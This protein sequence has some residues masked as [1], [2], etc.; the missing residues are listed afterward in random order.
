MKKKTSLFYSFLI[1]IT[2][3]FGLSFLPNTIIKASADEV[4]VGVVQVQYTN[5]N[6]CLDT[7]FTEIM[8]TDENGRLAAIATLSKYP[9]YF[10][11]GWVIKDTT[12]LITTDTVFT[13]PLTVLVPILKAKTFVYTIKQNPDTSLTVVGATEEDGL[14]YTLTTTAASLSDVHIA[15]NADNQTS[16]PSTLVFDNYVLATGEQITASKA[17][18]FSGNITSSNESSIFKVTA[19]SA[20]TVAFKDLTLTNNS[21]GTFIDI[22]STA[23]I[24]L[25]LDSVAFNTTVTNSTAINITDKTTITLAGTMSNTASKLYKYVEG[26]T[27][28]LTSDTLTATTPLNIAIDYVYDYLE[29]TTNVYPLNYDH[30][31]FVA[32]KDFYV[33]HKMMSNDKLIARTSLNLQYNTNGGQFAQGYTAPNVYYGESY[34]AINL[35]TTSNISKDYATFDGWFG[36]ITITEEQREANNLSATTYYFDL[37]NVGLYIY[38][39]A[40]IAD[41]DTYFKTDLNSFEIDSSITAYL[42]S[43]PATDYNYWANFFISFEARPTLIAKWNAILYTITFESNGGSTVDSYVKPQGETIARPEPTKT[44]YTFTNWYID[45]ELTTVY[46]FS[47]MPAESFTL[48]AGYQINSYTIN[49]E[50]NNG[51]S[52]SSITQEYLTSIE[53]PE[54]ELEGHSFAGWFTESTF[55]NEFTQ[56]TIPANNLTLY[57][58]WTR[59]SYAINLSTDGK[60]ILPQIITEYGEVPTAPEDPVYDGY[61]FHGWYTDKTYTTPFDFS[62][63]TPAESRTAYAKWTVISYTLTLVYNNGVA[64]SVSSK[65]FESKINVPAQPTRTGYLFAGW[66]SDSACTTRFEFT[67]AHMPAR[68]LTLYAKWTAK[69]AIALTLNKQTVEVDGRGV[70]S[71]PSNLSGFTVYYLVNNEWQTTTPTDIGTYDVKIVRAEDEQYATYTQILEDGFTVIQKTLDISWLPLTM[72]IVFIIEM[73]MVVVVKLLRKKKLTQ[74]IVI[75]TIALPFGLIPK[76]QFILSAATGAL[77]LFGFIYLVVELV[78]LHKTVPLKDEVNT[79]YDNRALLEKRGDKS[80]DASISS[81]VSNLLKKEGLYSYDYAKDDNYKIEEDIID[82]ADASYTGKKPVAEEFDADFELDTE[83][84]D[85]SKTDE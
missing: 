8:N 39:N 35:P 83:V 19:S 45:Q 54:L 11:K 55:D 25:N 85:E 48:Y 28:D 50:K 7:G 72:V 41:F 64:N 37:T 5:H 33:A 12:E 4:A 81:N 17:L 15:I 43:D 22:P 79:K 2:A 27:L 38:N 16:N 20:C 47:T 31:N 52:S 56:T 44:G 66:Y 18:I 1:A 24:T 42:Y 46:T 80:E 3:V 29:I 77:A 30:I 76:T 49:F 71:V 26:S 57:A 73:C 61:L 84:E 51:D 67:N 6:N 59:N 40:T 36:Q 53:F 9:N 34:E 10:L 69:I 75:Q 23:N 58:K 60:G 63:P 82:R 78:K 65:D 70:Y 68:N 74:T 21:Y 13:E 32:D 14:T 62:Q